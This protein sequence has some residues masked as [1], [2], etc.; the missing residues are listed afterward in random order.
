M[1]RAGTFRHGGVALAVHS[2]GAGR[3]M[4]FQHGLCGDAA[5][6]AE[7]FP[8]GGAWQVLTVESRGHGASEA[9]DPAEFSLATFADDLIAWLDDCELGPIPVGGISMGAALALRIAVLRPDLVSALILARPAWLF[10]A[11][12]A[13]LQP[14]REVGRLLTNHPAE[15]ARALFEAGPTARDL[16]ETS[17]DNLASLRGFFT[18]A[19]QAVTAALLTGIAGDGPG[20][21][22]RDAAAIRVPTLVIG[23][24][25][26][27]IHPLALARATADAIPGARMVEIPDKTTDHT[28]YRDGFAAA[29]RGFLATL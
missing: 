25:R 22:P 6:P 11:A 24:A 19:P 5:Q 7:V 9:G 14:N 12:P 29:L 17:P 28:A 3:A 2:T 27:A 1:T 16:A 21:L 8:A 20:I 4:L 10:A 18:R 15:E 26:D 13:N 23:S